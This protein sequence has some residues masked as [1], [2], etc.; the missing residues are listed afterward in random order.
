M[1]EIGKAIDRHCDHISSNPHMRISLA[2]VSES[3]G[4]R[5]V[6]FL[7]FAVGWFSVWIIR[8]RGQPGKHDLSEYQADLGMTSAGD[9]YD[10]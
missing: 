8:Y 6:C 9:K 3:I 7:C 10:V 1:E 5:W 4:L 2:S